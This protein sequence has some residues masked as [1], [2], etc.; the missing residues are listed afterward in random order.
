MFTA[1]DVEPE[2]SPDADRREAKRRKRMRRRFIPQ[3]ALIHL[4]GA[5]PFELRDR[6]SSG[7]RFSHRRQD[8]A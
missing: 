5:I 3:S 8:I 6:F 4:G 2:K 7:R 1:S